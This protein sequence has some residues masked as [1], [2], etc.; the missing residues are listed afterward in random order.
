MEKTLDL[1]QSMRPNATWGYY[2]Y[3]YCFNMNGNNKLPDCP[4]EVLPENDRYVFM[5][6]YNKI[7]R[8]MY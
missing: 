6:A 3:P 1:A 4:K 8:S 5:V 7:N 2:A